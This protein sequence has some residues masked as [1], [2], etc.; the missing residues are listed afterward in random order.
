MYNVS[1]L[2]LHF[3]FRI[4]RYKCI[5]LNHALCKNV[6]DHVG[7]TRNEFDELKHSF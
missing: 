5:L 4:T 2:N 1:K 6:Q 3:H 7:L